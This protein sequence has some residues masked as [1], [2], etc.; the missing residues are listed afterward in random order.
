MKP[1]FPSPCKGCE[2]RTVGCH[3]SCEAYQ[4]A[5][6]E[7]RVNNEVYRRENQG[8]LDA[9]IVKKDAT[10]KVLKHNHDR[11]GRGKYGQT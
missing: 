8:G 3:S 2:K 10:I 11:K 1:S 7:H 4:N 6:E 9:F 5:K